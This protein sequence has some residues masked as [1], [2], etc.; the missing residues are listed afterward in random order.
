ML[1]LIR[2]MTAVSN[3]LEDL[4]P[5]DRELPAVASLAKAATILTAMLSPLTKGGLGDRFL[6][7]AHS[8]W[9]ERQYQDRKWG[10]PEQHP[11]EVGGYILLME[12]HLARARAAW[13][14]T[15]SDSGALTELR[16]VIAIGVA[17]AEQHGMPSRNL[18]LA[19]DRMRG[20]GYKDTRE[21]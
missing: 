3:A 10:T 12:E 1:S 15:N 19:A 11:H 4:L 2:Q 17:C 18:T 20:E 9:T 13:S 14:S 7:A 16:K 5:E 21:S 6:R 8:I